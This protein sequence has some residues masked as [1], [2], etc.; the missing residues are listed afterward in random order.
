MLLFG[1]FCFD[2]ERLA[3]YCGQREIALRPKVAQLL[4]YFVARPNEL[5]KREAV[6][7][8]L[9]LHGEFREAALNQSITELRQALGDSAKRPLFIK[10]LPQQ[11][12]MWICDIKVTRC[13]RKRNRL[14]IGVALGV[15]LSLGSA[16]YMH[17]NSL[18]SY[19]QSQAQP[20]LII[21]SMQ[22]HTGV[23]AHAWW[24]YALEGVLRTRLQQDYQ[25]LPKS[26]TPD[27]IDGVVK[28]APQQFYLSLKPLQQRFLLQAE[29]AGRR[30]EV[31]VEQLDDNFSDIAAQLIASLTDSSG[32]IADQPL[33]VNGL[34]DYYR[35]VQ[36]LTEYGPQLAKQYFEAALI[37]A[38]DHVPS[39]LELAQIA[40]LQ[41]HIPEAKAH[42]STI[43]LSQTSQAL[44]ARYYLYLST[45]EKALGEF[46]HAKH[47]GQ[48]ALTAAQKSQQIELIASAYQLIADI[49][50]STTQWQDYTHAMSAAYA[51]IG[52]R[53]FAY[54]EAQRSFY[55]ANPPA[56][57]PQ[58]KNT[59]NLAQ[60][61]EVLEA[62]VRYYRQTERQ[63]DLARSLFA[64]GQNYL[65]PVSESEDSLLEALKIVSRSGD[66]YF[67][68]QVLTYLGFYYI[69]LHR[70]DEALSY[71]NQVDINEA[72]TPAIEQLNVL[73]AMA[74]MDIGLTT[75]N[76]QPLQEAQR[77]LVRLLTN[78]RTSEMTR[79]NTKLLL[80][81]VAL[82]LGDVDNAESLTRTAFKAYKLSG[83]DDAVVYAKYT[84]MYI[85]LLR[86]E[87]NQALELID[88][89]QDKDAHLMLF[90]ASVAAHMTQN[91]ALLE[92]SK[93]MLG[94]L[95]NSQLLLEQLGQFIQ[96]PQ[97][98]AKLITE[99][100]DAPYSVYCQS[101]WILE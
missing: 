6:L 92:Q 69:Q 58:Q 20:Q 2:S 42:F 38:P 99:L 26:R 94:E 56:A 49:A 76:H 30:T 52:S 47:S 10:T 51:L 21:H 15:V 80:A 96:Q 36:A 53:S 93:R 73:K 7:K 45:F 84:Q 100:L 82:K 72:F 33:L 81:W 85:Y 65:V 61:K 95:Q 70:G 35:G 25:L 37:H 68:V 31:I 28:E 57:G 71:L 90:Y 11:G 23:Q 3:L 19:G 67:Q 89:E 1:Q 55:L 83:L 74:Y 4:A 91:D 78:E 16:A 46:E 8:D 44:R 60:S 101:K 98:S 43:E 13:S 77:R 14:L 29:L 87:P 88:F 34:S 24:G 54:S 22:N 39:R 41:G 32:F 63:I 9:W 66:K 18:F 62:A 59:L 12:Y 17:S 27:Y 79:A 86:N 64:Y 97:R 40:W 5:V 50:W 75:D 48:L